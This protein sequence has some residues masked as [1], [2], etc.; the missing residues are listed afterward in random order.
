MTPPAFQF[1]PDDFLGGTIHFT[2]AEVGLYIRLLCVQWSKGKLPCEN[3]MLSSYGKGHTKV[4]RVLEKF[5]VCGDGFLRNKRMEQERKKQEKYRKSRSDNGKQGGRPQKAYGFSSLSKTKAKKSSPSPSPSPSPST[6]SPSENG[7]PLCSSEHQAFIKGWTEN[8][9]AFFGC[10]YQFAGGRDGKA[11]KELLA[12]G[13]AR[14]DLLE[15]AKNAWKRS[16][17]D[18]FASACKKSSTIYEFRAFINQ[19]QAELKRPISSAPAKKPPVESKE[20]E[21]HITIRTFQ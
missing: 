14:I 8:F 6:I 16:M 10:D 5:E 4:D 20:I 15:T 7:A 13:I 17:D 9:R 19:I 12:Y 3:H 18:R 11:V 21:E 2:D 1:Y